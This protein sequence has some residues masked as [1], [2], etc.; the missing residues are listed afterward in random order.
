MKIWLLGEFLGYDGYYGAVEE[1]IAAYST[2]EAAERGLEAK[3]QDKKASQRNWIE[4]RYEGGKTYPE[5]WGGPAG[6]DQAIQDAGKNLFIREVP[7][8]E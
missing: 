6:A 3:R 5:I 4:E 7:F 1:I 8:N 2:K